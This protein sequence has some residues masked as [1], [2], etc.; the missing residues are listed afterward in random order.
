MVQGAG[1]HAGVYVSA[2]VGG[3]GAVVSC[4]GCVCRGPRWV[5]DAHAG[6]YILESFQR[7]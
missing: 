6:V 4:G 5:R 2:W 7:G 3:G 1:V